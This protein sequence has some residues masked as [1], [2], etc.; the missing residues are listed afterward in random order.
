M[1]RRIESSTSTA[2]LSTSTIPK[3]NTNQQSNPTQRKWRSDLSVISRSPAPFPPVDH[4]CFVPASGGRKSP[5]SG[6]VSQAVKRE[7][8]WADAHRSPKNTWQRI[9]AEGCLVE[10]RGKCLTIPPQS[11]P[12]SIKGRF[13]RGIVL[14]LSATVLVLERIADARTNLR[15]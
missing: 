7:E 9:L 11:D 5:V 6:I 4:Y 15:P 3:R 2:M 1:F 10:S 14:V 13:V 8:Q 12:K